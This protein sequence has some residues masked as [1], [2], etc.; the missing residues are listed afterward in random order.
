MARTKTPKIRND[1]P[2]SVLYDRGTF[3]PETEVN[4]VKYIAADVVNLSDIYRVTTER[5][6]AWYIRADGTVIPDAEVKGIEA[7]FAAIEGAK[8][9]T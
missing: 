8:A 5:E 7:E 1:G 6:G 9:S 4:G 2:V 3:R